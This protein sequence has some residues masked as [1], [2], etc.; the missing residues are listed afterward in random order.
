M[1]MT[2]NIITIDTRL[3]LIK[4]DTYKERVILLNPNFSSITNVLIKPRGASMILDM[5]ITEKINTTPCKI[6][7]SKY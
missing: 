1:N 6:S 4:S 3:C 2:G 5:I 7:L